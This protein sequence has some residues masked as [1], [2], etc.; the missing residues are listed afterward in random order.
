MQAFKVWEYRDG[1]ATPTHI[2]MVNLPIED[3][4]SFPEVIQLPD[5]LFARHKQLIGYVIVPGYFVARYEYTE[6]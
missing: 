1:A 4:I 6:A 2:G 5:G 3:L